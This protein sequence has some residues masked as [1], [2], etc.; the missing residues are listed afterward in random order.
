[1]KTASS[2]EKMRLKRFK[3]RKLWNNW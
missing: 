3:S 2:K 1:M